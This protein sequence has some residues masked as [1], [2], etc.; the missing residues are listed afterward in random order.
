MK[1][2]PNTRISFLILTGRFIYLSIVCFQFLLWCTI[3]LPLDNKRAVEAPEHELEKK[4]PFSK[5]QSIAFLLTSPINF[6]PWR[7]RKTTQ[8]CIWIH[9]FLHKKN[10]SMTNFFSTKLCASLKINNA[11]LS[12]QWQLLTCYN[13]TVYCKFYCLFINMS[14]VRVH[15]W[16]GKAFI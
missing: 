1:C 10:I 9:V 3:V 16:V 14:I 2:T 8:N 5:M 11:S 4:N 7:H 6:S 13:I 12:R 15:S